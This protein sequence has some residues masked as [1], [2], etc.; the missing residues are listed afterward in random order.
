M[1]YHNNNLVNCDRCGGSFEQSELHICSGC[2][3][4]MCEA[5]YVDVAEQYCRECIDD[6]RKIVNPTFKT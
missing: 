2:G 3:R 6:G 1:D 4:E 5:C